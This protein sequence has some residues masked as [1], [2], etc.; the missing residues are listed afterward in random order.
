[1]LNF[2]DLFSR[3]TVTGLMVFSGA[4]SN[5]VNSQ[6][7]P[8]WPLTDKVHKLKVASRLQ[9]K[10]GDIK[11]AIETIREQ[12]PNYSLGANHAEHFEENCGAG[13]QN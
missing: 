9:Q 3:N 2:A 13:E 7:T 8:N 4:V 12:V 11:P 10:G 6:T 5:V 1:M